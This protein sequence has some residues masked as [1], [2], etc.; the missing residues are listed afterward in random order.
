MQVQL[1]FLSFMF[2]LN[3]ALFFFVFGNWGNSRQVQDLFPLWSYQ[4]WPACEIKPG[5]L[6]DLRVIS[7]HT[8]VWDINNDMYLKSP[9]PSPPAN[10]TW[11]NVSTS[12]YQQEIVHKLI[13]SVSGSSV[14]DFK[15]QPLFN[16]QY[17]HTLWKSHREIPAWPP[18]ESRSF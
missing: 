14:F 8:D 16:K 12:F 18:R 4:Y 3:I 2:S 1:V 10:Q 6:Q 5:Q 11:C 7:V 17:S 9:P 15:K 13:L